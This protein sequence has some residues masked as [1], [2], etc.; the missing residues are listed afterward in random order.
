MIQ[1]IFVGVL[2]VVAAAA[3]VWVWWIENGGRNKAD[4]ETKEA[5][6]KQNTK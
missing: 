6:P 4:E 1:D 5:D 2:L 3:S